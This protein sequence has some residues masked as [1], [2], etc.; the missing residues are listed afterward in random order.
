MQEKAAVEKRISEMSQDLQKQEDEYF[1]SLQKHSDG[2]KAMK[3]E[4]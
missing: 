1:E 2:L 4:V 3:S